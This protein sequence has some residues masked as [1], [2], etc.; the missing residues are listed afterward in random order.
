M[1]PKVGIVGNGNVG[2]AL[3]R[4]L[5][6]AG[7]QVRAVGKNPGEV[8]DTG[9]WADVVILAVPYGAIDE[10]IAELGN[11]IAGK[12]LVDVTNA[13]T[14][15]MQLASGCTTSGAEALQQKVRAAKVVK[16]FN[17]QFASHMDSG[18]VDGQQLTMFA[19]GDDAGARTQVIQMARDIGFDAVDAGPLQNAR[20]LEPL[21]Y[22][23]IQLGYALGLGTQI[24]LKL[25]HT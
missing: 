4:G 5:E 11:S 6:R 24:G 15:D 18:A 21:G 20:L 7:Y 12:T 23:N 25:V 14:G 1:K 3:R 16:A 19:A 13:L 10:A 22:F 17:T 9:G 2:G 8:K